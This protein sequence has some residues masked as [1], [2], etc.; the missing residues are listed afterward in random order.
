MS[1]KKFLTVTEASEVLRCHPISIYRWCTAGTLSS[2]KI[3][4]KRLIPASAVEA[5]ASPQPEPTLEQ[6]RG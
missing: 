2:V 5:L 1:E 6:V 4:G 3:G